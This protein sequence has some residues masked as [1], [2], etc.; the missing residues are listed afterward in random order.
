M[1]PGWNMISKVPS[2]RNKH[3]MLYIPQNT[4][5]CPTTGLQVIISLQ[6][7]LLFLTPLY[8]PAPP[9]AP[10]P[11]LFHL[12]SPSFYL[13]LSLFLSVYPLP[14]SSSLPPIFSLS[15]LPTS[16]LS[17]VL[18][19]SLSSSISISS[20]PSICHTHTSP[21]Y[22]YVVPHIIVPGVCLAQF[23]LNNVHKRSLKHHFISF[24]CGP[25]LALSLSLSFPV[26]PLQHRIVQYM[27]M[28]TTSCVHYTRVNIMWK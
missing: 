4:L 12:L 16:P 7:L 10:S 5:F 24:F 20:L 27:Y 14:L 1:S 19:I 3:N 8:I 28:H 26:P 18:S 23:S 9:I 11:T 15:S 2:T 17:F 22:L 21:L 6:H 13:K 25:S